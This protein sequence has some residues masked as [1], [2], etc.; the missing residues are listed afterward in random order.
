MVKAPAK[1]IFDSGAVVESYDPSVGLTVAEE[2]LIAQ[3]VRD[4]ARV[5]DLGVGTGRT[6]PA[7]AKLASTYV[8]LDIAPQ[9]VFAARTAHPVGSFLVADAVHLPVATA[10][11]DVVVFSYNGLDYL[12]PE[13]TRRLAVDEMRRVLRP[14]GTLI[15]SSHNARAIARLAPAGWLRRRGWKQGAIAL[16]ATA[17]STRHLLPSAVFWRGHGYRVDRLKPLLTYFTSPDRLV[18]ELRRA[19]FD[20]VETVASDHPRRVHALAS[21]WVYAAARA[22]ADLTITEHDGMPADLVAEW[23][24]LCEKTSASWFQGPLWVRAW[25]EHLEPGAPISTLSASDADGSLVGVLPLARLHR[26]LHRSVPIPLPYV[27]IAGSGSGGADHTGPVA[28][29][30]EV[31]EALLRR[32]ADVAGNLSLLLENLHPSWTAAARSIPGSAVTAAT[33]CPAVSVATGEK[34]AA[35]W[36]T[37]QRKN[38]ARR[39]RQLRD[40]GVVPRWTPPGAGTAAALEELQRV[41][42]LRWAERGEEGLFDDRR[43][44]F[45]EAQAIPGSLDG[46][47]VLLLDHSGGPVA[48]LLGLRHGSTFSVYKTG[49]DP[50]W[51][52]FGLGIALGAEAMRWAS[53]HGITTFDYLRGRRPHKYDLGCTDVVDESVILP[54]GLIGRVLL[55]RERRAGAAHAAFE[56]SRTGQAN[57]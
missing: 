52:R 49:W 5:L 28:E 15:L 43:R 14:G 32:A 51:R 54:R 7:L 2:H 50:G 26:N 48:G 40:A 6:F 3:W 8:G 38:I 47:W 53:E 17:R 27:G 42:Q 39:D 24:R 4:G 10:S 45:L 21:P 41:H 35:H 23:A 12:H 13:P 57:K 44:R 31:G 22:G 30:L 55:E 33:A 11:F 25:S 46:P 56:E 1:A 19:G 36:D 37:K 29:R 16:A 18:A 9:M 20:V 34:F